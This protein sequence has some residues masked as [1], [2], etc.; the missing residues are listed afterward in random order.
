MSDEGYIE[1]GLVASTTLAFLRGE[2]ESQGPKPTAF[3]TSMRAS[4]AHGCE[5]SLALDAAQVPECEEIGYETLLAFKLGDAMHDLV[6]RGV[7][8]MFPD[9]KA[10]VPVDLRPFGYDVS[11]SADGVMVEGDELTVHEIKTMKPY[12]FNLSM[13]SGAPRL[14]DILQAGIYVYGMGADAIRFIY[15]CKETDK[16]SGRVPGDTQEFRLRMGDMVDEAG[17]TVKSLVENELM[18]LQ[19]IS[20]S[21]ADGVIP[22]RDIPGVGL[23]DSPPRYQADRGQPWNCRFCRHNSTCRVMESGP[24]PVE[25]AASFVSEAWTAPKPVDVAA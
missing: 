1:P 7:A 25:F 4:S 12:P 24:V 14:G 2:R 11:G 19:R 5:R 21:A 3:G 13:T 10:E 17:D 15:I 18:R 23:V 16:R 22:P 6:Q 20:E 8:A 9:F